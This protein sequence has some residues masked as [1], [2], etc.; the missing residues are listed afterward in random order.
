MRKPRVFTIDVAMD[1]VD[2]Y[3]AEIVKIIE[4]QKGIAI[5]QSLYE[6]GK[7]IVRFLFLATDQQSYLVLLDLTEDLGFEQKAENGRFYLSE[8]V[9][10]D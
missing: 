1:Y 5:I 2:L 6:T 8:E 9:W 3:T 10:N 7:G 4:A